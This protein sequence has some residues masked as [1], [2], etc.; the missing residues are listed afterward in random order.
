[1]VAHGGS[2]VF[3]LLKKPIRFPTSFPGFSPTRPYGTRERRVGEITWERGCKVST[4]KVI[5]NLAST[6]GQDTQYTKFCLIN[7][8]I[9]E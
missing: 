2:T 8:H 4:R 7:Q 5:S 9:N 6:Q 3:T 1:M